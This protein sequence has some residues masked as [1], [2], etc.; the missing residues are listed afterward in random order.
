MGGYGQKRM[1][2]L[3]AIAL[4]AL[5]LGAVS[6]VVFRKVMVVKNIVVEGVDDRCV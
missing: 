3:V 4:V 1:R 6:G 2:M 5:I